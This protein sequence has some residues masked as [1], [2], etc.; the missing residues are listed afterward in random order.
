MRDEKAVSHPSPIQSELIWIR[1]LV[2][3][4]CLREGKYAVVHGSSGDHKVLAFLYAVDRLDVQASE[5]AVLCRQKI[6]RLKC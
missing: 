6:T 5:L 4:R 2:R 3:R 1:V